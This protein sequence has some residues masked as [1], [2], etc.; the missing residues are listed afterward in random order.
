MKRI[1]TTLI[2]IAVVLCMFGCSGKKIEGTPSEVIAECQSLK[3]DEKAEVTVTGYVANSDLEE[4]TDSQGN[5]YIAVCVTDDEVGMYESY[6]NQE[7]VFCSVENE[8]DFDDLESCYDQND[9]ITITGI[10]SPGLI[11][12]DNIYLSQCNLGDGL[13]NIFVDY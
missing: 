8:D 4:D 12:P 5:S 3:T 6:V 2:S 11:E 13:D 1:A 10:V 9:R 7:Y